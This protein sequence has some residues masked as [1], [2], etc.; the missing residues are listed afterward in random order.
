V[1]NRA[2]LPN[3]VEPVAKLRFC[4]FNGVDGLRPHLAVHDTGADGE[5]KDADKNM[6]LQFSSCFCGF[7]WYPAVFSPCGFDFNFK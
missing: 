2:Q 7:I 3:E 4:D 6:F 1:S 5:I